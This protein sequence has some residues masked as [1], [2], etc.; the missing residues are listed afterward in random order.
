MQHVSSLPLARIRRPQRCSIAPA[1]FHCSLSRPSPF[2]PP[3]LTHHSAALDPSFALHSAT[4]HS[5]LSFRRTENLPS[6]CSSSSNCARTATPYPPLVVLQL[7]S[8]KLLILQQSVERQPTTISSSNG[9]PTDL[10]PIPLRTFDARQATARSTTHVTSITSSNSA[11]PKYNRLSPTSFRSLNVQLSPVNLRLAQL[12]IEQP[13]QTSPRTTED[14]T[15]SPS[16]SLT[17]SPWNSPSQSP[18]RPR[19]GG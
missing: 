13:T 3:P 9:T 2:T 16:Y 7:P 8:V 15:A 5:Y 18:P 12:C 17:N 10:V 4:L 6:S 11:T 19:D 1:A 14:T